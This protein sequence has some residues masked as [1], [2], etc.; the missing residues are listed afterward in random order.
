MMFFKVLY[1]QCG[2]LVFADDT[3]LYNMV[4]NTNVSQG[5][6]RQLE[7]WERE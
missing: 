6:L 1:Q 3:M 2:S 5:A 4:K 7:N